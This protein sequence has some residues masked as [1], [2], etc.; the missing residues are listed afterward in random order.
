MAKIIL[1]DEIHLSLFVPPGL[2]TESFRGIRRALRSARLQAALRRAIQG[3]FARYA[4]LGNVTF[5][6]T[7]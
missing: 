4:A 1:I 7:R 5:T 6:L 2:R 3:V